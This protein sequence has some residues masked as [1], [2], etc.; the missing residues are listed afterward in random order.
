MTMFLAGVIG[1]T[2]PHAMGGEVKVEKM[3]FG[4]WTNCYRLS[5]GEVELV[6]VADVGPRVISLRRTGGENLFGVNEQDQGSQGGE[7]WK[8]YGGHRFWLGPEDPNVTYY[9]DNV[10]VHATVEGNRLTLTS[11]PEIHD[12]ALRRSLTTWAAVEPKLSDP[13]FRKKIGIQKIMIITM[14]NDGTITVEHQA[15]NLGVEP[16]ALAP[17][18]LSVMT[19]GG[20]TIIPNAP[21]ASHGVGHY[22]A[23]RSLNLW[24]YTDLTDPRLAFLKRY[25]I[26]KQD[27]S[28]QTPLKIGFS[29]CSGWVAYALKNHL[30]VKYLDHQ[31]DATYVDL[32][33]SL[34]LFT[35]NAIMEIESLG[36]LKT[37][38]PNEMLSHR[39]RWRL[40]N[41]E[42]V[43]PNESSIDQAIQSVGLAK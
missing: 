20:I 31:P 30:F 13:A 41:I 4:G 32:G 38:K 35:N 24:S 6:A 28:A 15:K 23:V 33:S 10:E 25:T 36:P 9:P 29:E 12:A 27:P 17:W 2:I 22:L 18:A 40:F 42:A 7:G 37:L 34:E 5:N 8:S 14:D 21:F 39:E 43:S 1:I 26:L 16:I 3:A 11:I 19:R